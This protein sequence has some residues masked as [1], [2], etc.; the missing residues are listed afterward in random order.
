MLLM[1]S[2]LFLCLCVHNKFGESGLN[3]VV[4]D[5][6]RN[7][8]APPNEQIYFMDRH[9]MC[10]YFSGTIHPAGALMDMAFQGNRKVYS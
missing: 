7:S 10:L 5:R 2:H 1:C 6:E 4:T 8:I 3:F 9:P